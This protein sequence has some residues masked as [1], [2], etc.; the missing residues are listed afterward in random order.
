MLCALESLHAIVTDSR[1]P[2]ELVGQLRERGLEV[3]IAPLNG[4]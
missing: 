3:V 1:A 4:G 2:A